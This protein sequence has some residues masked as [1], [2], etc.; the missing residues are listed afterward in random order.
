LSSATVVALSTEDPA[1]ESGS[2]SV[3]DVWC[4]QPSAVSARW[5]MAD[6]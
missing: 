6:G 4:C 3:S 2:D 5:L 1:P